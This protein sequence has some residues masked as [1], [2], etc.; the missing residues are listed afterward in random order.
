MSIFSASFLLR[1]SEKCD[2][3]NRIF[4]CSSGNDSAFHTGGAY[5]D[6]SR[7]L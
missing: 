6:S 1:K 5:E 3:I 4:I 2:I 7:K